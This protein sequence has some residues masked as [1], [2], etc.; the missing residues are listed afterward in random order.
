M[1]KRI[2]M[3]L[4][5]VSVLFMSMAVYLT[6]FEI[7]QAEELKKTPYNQRLFD[8]ENEVLRGKIYDCE[9]TILA[10]S[11]I[12]DGESL[13]FYPFGDLYTHVIGY[14]SKVYGK[15]KLEFSFNDYL[16]GNSTIGE[17]VNLASAMAGEAKKGMDL[18]L[19]VDHKLQ[20]YASD[21]LG[22]KKGCIIVMDADS[23]KIRAMV[24]KP[25]FNPEEPVLSE[26]WGDLEEGADSPFLARATAGLYAPGSTWKIISSAAVIE[27]GLEEELL[28]DRGKIIV[29]GREYKNSGEKANGEIALDRAFSKSSNVYFAKMGSDLGKDGL[30]IYDDFL[31]GKDIDFDIPI[32]RS[33]L[34]DKAS[35]MSEADIAST[36]IGQGKL[37]VTPLYMTMV[38]SSV[39]NG[40]KM[41]KPYLVEKA[42]LG[43][44][45]AYEAENK[46]L[47]QPLSKST[48]DKIKKM[49]ELCVTEGTGK[50][51]SVSNLKVYGK[52]GTA[53]NE[54]DKSHDWFIGFAENDEGEKA[55]IC[56]MLEYNGVGSSEAASMAGRVFSYWL[57]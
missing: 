27:A 31:L 29:G 41:V 18:T 21:I 39:A 43:D 40:G 12:V 23:G 52:T 49:M 37:R 15:S 13:R 34:A 14:N 53:Q 11:K 26:N 4:T 22:N 47:A 9:G 30:D 57:G 6:I 48:A 56:V 32:E 45:V 10:E 3:L 8:M 1:N 5:M 51:A 50:S 35:S 38:A 2:I 17:A 7:T 25:T 55:A 28:D 36:S 54:T 20:S 42:V 24:S 46:T 33:N 19:T 44:F 16:M